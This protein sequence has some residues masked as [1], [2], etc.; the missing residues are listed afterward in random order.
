M[1]QLSSAAQDRVGAEEEGDPAGLTS[2]VRMVGQAFGRLEKSIEQ[3]VARLDKTA[4][5]AERD[6]TASAKT[7]TC[8]A[9]GPEEEELLY[10]LRLGNTND[11]RIAK[12][13]KGKAGIK[14]FKNQGLLTKVA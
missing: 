5:Q 14:A 2:L 8:S 10:T 6:K 3:G 13:E 4:A 11:V 12:N 7:G 9:I 1:G